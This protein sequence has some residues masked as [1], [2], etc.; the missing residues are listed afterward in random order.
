LN[1]VLDVNAGVG[2]AV[3][4]LKSISYM[5]PDGRLIAFL[6]RGGW[7]LV[8]YDVV[9]GRVPSLDLCFRTG[10]IERFNLDSSRTRAFGRK[11]DVV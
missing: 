6:L 10:M 4:T 9:S 3:A 11:I 2:H 5:E 8:Q 1:L 7:Q